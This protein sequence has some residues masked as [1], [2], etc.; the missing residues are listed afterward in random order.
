[1]TNGL[2]T[3]P[4]ANWPSDITA[5]VNEFYS[6]YDSLQARYEQRFSHGLTLLN[7][8]TWEHSLDNASASLE[9][10]TPSPQDGNNIRADYSQS[11]Y[12]LPVIDV[13][14]LVYEL[15]FGRG[16]NFMANANPFVDAFFGG[17]QVSLINTAQ[18]GTPFNLTYSPNSA[19]A[20]SPGRERVPAECR[21]GAE[22]HA[23]PFG[24][25][26]EH[27]ICPVR[28]PRRVHAAGDE[29]RNDA[30]EPVWQC[31]AQPRPDAG[32]L[33]ERL[34][35]EQAFLDAGRGA[36]G[37]VPYG[38]LQPVQSHEPVPSVKRA[39]RHAGLGHCDGRRGDQQHLRAPNSAVRAEDHLLTA[40]RVP[41]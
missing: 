5:A 26:G 7:S 30:V 14:S 17:W 28:Q 22:D 33:R 9:A 15:P 8:F 2:F 25:C 12:N 38:V 40:F 32:L 27:G 36:E 23:G 4:Y 20:V 18:A 29:E 16:R 31:L 41:L 39:Q 24:S 37:R 11:D 6:H 1:M 10:N 3:R 34:R 35:P 21:S 19:T 13:T